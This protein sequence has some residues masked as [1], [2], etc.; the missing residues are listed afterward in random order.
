M[1]MQNNH[2]VSKFIVAYSTKDRTDF[3]FQTIPPILASGV[4][5][6]WFDGSNTNTGRRFPFQFKRNKNLLNIINDV[7]GGPDA[8]IIFALDY[9][10]ESYSHEWIILIENDVLV[11]DGWLLALDESIRAAISDGLNVGSATARVYENRLFRKFNKYGLVYNSGAGFIAINRKLIPPLLSNYRTTS[12]GEV[13]N[14]YRE[15]G[16]DLQDI[17]EFKNHANDYPLSADWFFEILFLSFGFYSICT[18]GT[19]SKNIDT[20][21][22]VN[23]RKLI[24]RA[25]WVEEKSRSP[26]QSMNSL[27]ITQLIPLCDGF[28]LLPIYHLYVLKHNPL[29]QNRWMKIWNQTLGPIGLTTRFGYMRFSSDHLAVNQLMI[30]SK[31]T[32]LNFAIIFHEKSFPQF[33]YC[34]KKGIYKT[35]TDKSTIKGLFVIGMGSLS[36][37]GAIFKYNFYSHGFSDL[38]NFVKFFRS[39]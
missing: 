19:Y 22:Y 10:Y 21:D 25:A 1:S 26:V 32:K 30:V 33:I 17:W 20:T 23:N 34:Y 7:T 5:V 2:V 8:A 27:N 13:L 31:R 6:V 24:S 28:F 37:V 29:V 12:V 9:I 15:S 4:S 35:Q 16:V 36:V 3:T 11:E 39:S 18:T 38:V 14:S